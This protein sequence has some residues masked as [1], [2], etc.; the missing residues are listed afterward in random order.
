MENALA[1]PT[2]N[3]WT[4]KTNDSA[5]QGLK[6]LTFVKLGH[7]VYQIYI[8]FTDFPLLNLNLTW[9]SSSTTRQALRLEVGGKWK[10]ILLLLE[11]FFENI[12]N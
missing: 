9:S 1:I 4:M 11:Q 5:A 7:I 2:L 8:S 12:C 6:L 3:K 10:K